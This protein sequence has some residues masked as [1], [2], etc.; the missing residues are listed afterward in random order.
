MVAFKYCHLPEGY[1]DDEMMM[2]TWLKSQDINMTLLMS[3]D[4]LTGFISDRQQLFFTVWA[5]VKNVQPG[6][7]LSHK[8]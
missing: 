7:V 6:L 2:D 8:W 3:S 1:H 4:T 5:S